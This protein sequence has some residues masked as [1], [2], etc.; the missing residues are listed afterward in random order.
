MTLGALASSGHD[1]SGSPAI[2]RT[3]LGHWLDGDDAAI[4]ALLG[5]FYES[6]CADAVRMRDL[7]ALDEPE[8]FAGAAHRLRGAALSMGARALADVAGLLFAAAQA[9][10]RNA[11]VN[12]MPVL[13]THVQLVADE[14]TAATGVDTS[15]PND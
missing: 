3:V 12:G 7:L 2:D 11:C 4:N 8:Q 13:E 15:Q 1:T 5:I 10:D 6:I 9:K 14:V